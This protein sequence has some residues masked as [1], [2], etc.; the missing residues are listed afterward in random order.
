MY[1]WITLFFHQEEVNTI[2][3]IT[4]K[5]WN[6]GNVIIEMSDFYPEKELKVMVPDTEKILAANLVNQ[7]EDTCKA[8]ITLVKENEAREFRAVLPVAHPFANELY[9]TLGKLE[10]EPFLRLEEGA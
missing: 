4:I 9:I 6:G 3:V 1:Y 7:T 10:E 2:A 8:D 5:I